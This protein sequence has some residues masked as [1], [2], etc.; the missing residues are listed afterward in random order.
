MK[1]GSGVQALAFDQ[2]SFEQEYEV[3][4]LRVVGRR[5][6]T[7]AALGGELELSPGRLIAGRC[8]ARASSRAAS[9]A[10]GWKGY[11]G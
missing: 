3:I 9:A 1:L 11:L 4:Q 5:F 10:A 8:G 2:G 6:S 7:A